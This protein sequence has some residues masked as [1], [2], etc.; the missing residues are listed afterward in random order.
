M[1]T[2]LLSLLIACTIQASA[3]NMTGKL[4]RIPPPRE[5]KLTFGWVY[6]PEVSYRILGESELADENTSYVI[7]FRNDLERIKYGHTF[8]LF[9]GY[10][11][12]KRFTL[13]AGLSYTD[14]GEGR[15]PQDLLF[16]S[17][18]DP[19]VATLTGSYNIHV[20]S[21]PITLHVNLGE[22]R[23]RGFISAGIAPSYFLKYTTRSVIDYNNGDHSISK[24][25]SANSQENYSKFI[26]GAHISGGIDYQY[27]KKVK[28]R[29][30]PVLRITATDTYSDVP[31]R[32]NYFNAGIEMGM[33]YRLFHR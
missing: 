12:S 5:S 16:G 21:V 4:L 30:A 1:K 24:Q 26:L 3:Q 15:K 11:L 28:F 9:L 20:A 31:I 25:T 27:N 22:K 19:I 33:I 32:A 2:V 7:D 6:S 14:F 8:S 23:V 18:P 10:D 17:I 13:E 29:I